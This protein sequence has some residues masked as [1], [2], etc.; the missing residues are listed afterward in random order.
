[1][2]R[3]E[4]IPALSR[5]EL[6][7]RVQNRKRQIHR[8][9]QEIDILERWYQNRARQELSQPPARAAAAGGRR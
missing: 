1:M 6:R 4:E 9:Q 2:M 8:L 5:G 3:L 7:R